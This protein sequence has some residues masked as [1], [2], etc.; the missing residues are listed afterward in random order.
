MRR[1]YQLDGLR[2]MLALFVVLGHYTVVG[3][4]HTLP[5]HVW[6][7]QATAGAV[8]VFLVLSGYLVASRPRPLMSHL[9]LRAA[10]ILP[11]WWLM[12]ALPA[13]C[14]LMPS[15]AW[16]VA[17]VGW[18]PDW[19][20]AG[21]ASPGWS[22]TVELLAYAAMPML[23]Y[24]RPV[25]LGLLFVLAMAAQL[26]GAL[27]M[28]AAVYAAPWARMGPVLLGVLVARAGLP[29]SGSVPW[30][31]VGGLLAWLAAPC[32]AVYG[33]GPWWLA[34]SWAASVAGA[35]ALVLCLR[36]ELPWL[37][38]PPLRWTGERCLG[39]YLLHVPA[40]ALVGD[41]AVALVVTVLLTT[42]SWDLL[43]RPVM[44]A[45]RRWADE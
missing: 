38:W 1:S 33:W 34:S 27:A 15:W 13:A 22:L 4:A 24:R 9:V 8:D 19:R 10:R 12:A 28:G 6:T 11:L 16:L 7:H 25:W 17:G 39:V 44:R 40:L 43:E 42:A 36:G 30:W 29:S 32:V 37:D 21:W 3:G 14:G 35:G 41:P 2:G 31:L 5:A 18:L 20:G 26:W 45:A 23:W